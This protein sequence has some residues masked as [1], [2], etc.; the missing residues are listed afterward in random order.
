M[1]LK[2]LLGSLFVNKALFLFRLGDCKL[3]TCVWVVQIKATT[4]A[5]QLEETQATNNSHA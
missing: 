4:W 5:G 3:D 1:H 2:G